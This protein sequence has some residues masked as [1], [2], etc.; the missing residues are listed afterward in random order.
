ML[1]SPDHRSNWHAQ[2]RPLGAP[3]HRTET[4]LHARHWTA[5]GLETKQQQLGVSR[6]SFDLKAAHARFGVPKVASPQV[7]RSSPVHKQ[8][9]LIARTD[10]QESRFSGLLQMRRQRE[11]A[12]VLRRSTNYLQLGQCSP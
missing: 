12:R 7:D 1:A 2:G 3:H 5:S 4:R 6:G 10:K 9:S 8:A 11:E